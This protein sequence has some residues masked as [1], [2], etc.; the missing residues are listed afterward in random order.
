MNI[1]LLE[2]PELE[3]GRAGRHVDIRFGIK[4]HGP[5]S[6]DDPQAP[7]EIKIGIVGTANTIEKLITWLDEC[8]KPIAAKV[9]KKPNLFPSFPG[10]APD[11]SFNCDWMTSAEKLQRSILPREFKEIVEGNQRNEAVKLIA[12]RFIEECRYLTENSN[13]EVLICAPPLDLFEK[14]DLP[15]GPGDEDDAPETDAPNFKIDFHD[16]LKA[17]SLDLKKPIQFVRPPT[18]DPD[19]KQIRSTGNPRSLQDPATRAWN[20]HTALYYKAKGVPWRLLRRTSDLDSAYVGISFYLSADKQSIH[21]S[22]AQVFNERGEGMVV[23]GGEA[24]RSEID[25]QVHLT[26]KGI[27]DLVENVLAE[28]K[29][30]HKNLPAR[31]VVHKTSNFNDAEKDGCNEALKYLRVDTRDLLVVGDSFVRLYRNGEYPPLRG[32]FMEMDEKSWFLYTR[33]SVDFY[34]AYPGMYV[35]K[36]LEIT[37]VETDESPRK[38]AEEILALTKMNWNNTQFDNALP[39]T[40]K[41]AR[42]VGAIL[43]HATD[44]PKIEASYAYY[45]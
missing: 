28:Y 9:S 8:R 38:L 19:A 42:Q 21:T 6:I 35:P 23:R 13:A 12:D 22:V 1:Q 11:R 3:F 34:M 41:A 29:K 33:G 40:I 26:K 2:E 37:P 25:R 14:F 7:K 31:I 45:M 36:S 18:Y 17:R 27:R 44:I 30:H 10:F 5:V 16:Y 15:I 20:F 32:T 24:K 39:I 43:K 4:A